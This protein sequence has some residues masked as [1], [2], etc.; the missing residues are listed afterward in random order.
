MANKEDALKRLNRAF[1]ESN[2]VCMT[3]WTTED[4]VIL[5]REHG[6]EISEKDAEDVLEMAEGK[7]DAIYGI[8]WDTLWIYAQDVIAQREEEDAIE[9]DSKLRTKFE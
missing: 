8:S 5:C 7:S 2:V 3:L 6:K 1:E 9:T 4:V